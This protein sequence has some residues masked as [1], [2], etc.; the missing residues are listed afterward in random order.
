M[1]LAWERITGQ[2]FIFSSFRI[3]ELLWL[4]NAMTS[5]GWKKRKAAVKSVP[6]ISAFQESEQV[7]VSITMQCNHKLHK[8]RS[9][10]TYWYRTGT[11]LVWKSCNETV[12]I[13][14]SEF[15]IKQL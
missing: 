11:V 5:F 13:F 8:G 7:A 12:K 3:A 10:G 6:D 9:A 4:K 15:F 1:N 14:T 2:H